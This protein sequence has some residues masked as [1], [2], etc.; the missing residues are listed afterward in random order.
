VAAHAPIGRFT[1]I[2]DA[3]VGTAG[4][5][6]ALLF[7]G[8]GLLAL[9]MAAVLLLAVLAAVRHAEAVGAYLGEPFGTLTL[10]IAVT[11]IEAGLIISLILAASEPNP[12]LA[13]DAVHAVVVLVIHG[14][15]GLCIV[16]G[17]LRHRE[18]EFSTRGA[19]AFLGV[20]LPLA[21]LTLVLP[22]HVVSAAG[23]YY[24]TTQL[25][26]VSVVCLALYASFVFVQTVRHPGL[27]IGPGAA[28]DT[29]HA[30]PSAAAAGLS[31]VLM[32]LVLTAV[33]LLGK[34]LGPAVRAAINALGAPLRLE[35]VII[36]AIVL[37][38]EAATAV[39]AAARDRLQTAL[40]LALGSAV[41][42]IGL[43]IPVVAFVSWWIGQPLGLGVDD[44]ATVLLA[45]S[46]LV[47]MIT[48]GTGRTTLLSGLEQ[49][50]QPHRQQDQVN[51]P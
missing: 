20:L 40:N 10:A 7:Y 5:A 45:L 33:V 24:T 44:S 23:P 25:A 49:H 8:Q 34:A 14:L 47:A 12:F 1:Y 15:A 17:T 16:V 29:Q 13:R 18:Q 6:G 38:P 4:V 42:C 21:A 37:M 26:F 28:N 43:T 19:G 9:A 39:R 46:F 32:V 50:E 27:F 48:Y 11:V 35:G 30:K 2:R 22:N 36:A 41:A 3:A 51:Q 31:F